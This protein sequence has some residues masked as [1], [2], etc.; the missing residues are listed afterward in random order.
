MNIS[1]RA[2]LRHSCW[3]PAVYF[4]HMYW[5]EEVKKISRLCFQNFELPGAL[6]VHILFSRQR[7]SCQNLRFHTKLCIY[8]PYVHHMYKENYG[9][10]KSASYSAFNRV[11]SA[12]GQ[13][14]QSR[15]RCPTS[16]PAKF[17]RPHSL[18]SFWCLWVMSM[19]WTL[20]DVKLITKE[21]IQLNRPTQRAVVRVCAL[22]YP[23][24]LG[25]SWFDDTT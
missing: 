21:Q 25:D 23:W 4:C 3:D 11:Q 9:C 17:D 22:T 20:L 6:N 14:D 18:I 19:I 2:S 1:K 8:I 10:R 13:S 16:N 24:A 5:C 15:L 7:Q 12:L